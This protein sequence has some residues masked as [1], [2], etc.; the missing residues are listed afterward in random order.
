VY[1]SAVLIALVTCRE[2]PEADAET[3]LLIAP[4]AERGVS[5]VPVVWDDRR[6]DWS[7]FDLAV[8]RSCWDY[9]E[10]REEFLSWAARVPRLAN[11]AAVLEWNTD[12]RYF[13]DL[14]A[15]GIPTI[16]TVWLEPG[17]GWKPI[18][19]MLWVIKPAVSLC[20]LDSGRYDWGDAEQR[21]LAEELVRRILAGGR[22]AMLQPYMEGID[23]AGETSLVFIEGEFSHAVR[24]EAVLRGP[25]R[26]VD[27]R[28]VP[29]GG[30]VL[31]ACDPTATQLR[32]AR[33]VLEAVPGEGPGRLLY[34]R[35]DLVPG[36]G[37]EPVLMEVELTE[38]SLFLDLYPDAVERL[39]ATLLRWVAA[40]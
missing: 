28:F 22:I 1:T 34:A 18:S 2:L 15:A 19:P 38:P 13:K 8:V 20:S 30:L 24:R 23:K 17:V 27:K 37:G 21:H 26:G 12:K 6:V 39:A 4:L 9:H 3:R 32:L 7:D 33:R 25:D 40:G 31:T 29:Q 36:F 11:P 35:V 10:R 16:P 14:E 5:A